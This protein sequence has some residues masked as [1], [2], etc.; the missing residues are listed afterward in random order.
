MRAGGGDLGDWL[1]NCAASGAL[2]AGGKLQVRCVLAAGEGC[3]SFPGLRYV[4]CAFVFTC[5]L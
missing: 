4:G 1:I 2:V 5:E 3:F